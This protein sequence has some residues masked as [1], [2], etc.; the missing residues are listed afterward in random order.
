MV[1]FNLSKAFSLLRMRDYLAGRPREEAK[2][3]IQ[4]ENLFLENL[5]KKRQLTEPTPSAK[6]FAKQQLALEKE[7]RQQAWEEKTFI[8]GKLVEFMK[9]PATDPAMREHYGKLSQTYYFANDPKLRALLDPLAKGTP[10]D[11]MEQKLMAFDRQYP[12]PQSPMVRY[13]E[14]QPANIN[15]ENEREWAEYMLRLGEWRFR[16]AVVAHGAT[17]AKAAFAPP[18]FVQVLAMVGEGED[19]RPGNLWYIDKQT[20]QVNS[21]SQ[22]IRQ[23]DLDQ[24]KKWGFPLEV[25][26]ARGFM[27]TGPPTEGVYGG[28]KFR[29]TPGVG[30][31]DGQTRTDL[32]FY[33][34]EDKD[35]KAIPKP[36]L[37]AFAGLAHDIDPTDF[38][39]LK[40]DS[41]AVS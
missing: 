25:I 16:R 23:V 26:K 24:A 12:R 2:S 1:E 15:E 22:I 37:E 34:K 21:I 29:V 20:D 11:P 6:E 39:D 36:W 31:P 33:G 41:D 28:G 10:L 30:L 40:R 8:F 17:E 5:L 32:Q 3:Q 18:R 38:D 19:R 27:P 13:E 7:Q 4:M 35:I 14:G 9:D